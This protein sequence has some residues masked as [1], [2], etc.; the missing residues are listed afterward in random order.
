MSKCNSLT[1]S[2]KRLIKKVCEDLEIDRDQQLASEVILADDKWRDRL[3]RRRKTD[4]HHATYMHT[5]CSEI[6]IGGLV[7]LGHSWI[8]G[9]LWTGQK[10]LQDGNLNR[11]NHR[12]ANM[13]LFVGAALPWP[14]QP[15]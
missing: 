4:G 14:M 6:S 10:F 1:G 7:R 3:H 13:V 9:L 11:F 5:T 2:F 15:S 12:G 8:S